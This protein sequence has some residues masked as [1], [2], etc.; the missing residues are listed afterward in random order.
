MDDLCAF[1]TDRPPFE[2]AIGF[3]VEVVMTSSDPD[4]AE[5][6]DASILL[7]RCSM[8]R[9]GRVWFTVECRKSS[10]TEILDYSVYS[11]SSGSYSR[12]CHLL[13]MSAK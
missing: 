13:L 5:D 8:Y 10:D 2:A 7:S 11:G 6:V 9:W 4:G 3:G 1:P 12:A